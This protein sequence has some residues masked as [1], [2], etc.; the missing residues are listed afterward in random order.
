MPNQTWFDS[1]PR[2][3]GRLISS[4][5]TSGKQVGGWSV[6]GTEGEGKSIIIFF[7]L[8]SPLSGSKELTSEVTSLH[9]NTGKSAGFPGAAQDPPACLGY[10]T[11]KYH[12]SGRFPW[13]IRLD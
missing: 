11:S 8:P 2:S 10:R 9:G 1:A 12:T 6:E 3:S 4:W 13:G 5:E 7:F